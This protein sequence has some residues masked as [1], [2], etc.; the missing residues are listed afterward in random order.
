MLRDEK[1]YGG[2]IL[3][4]SEPFL[5]SSCSFGHSLAVQIDDLNTNYFN[6]KYNVKKQEIPLSHILN[7]RN[8]L[9]HCSFSF[10]KCNEISNDRFHCK[11]SAF[12]T[13]KASTRISTLSNSE[14][15]IDVDLEYVRNF[16]SRQFKN[17]IQKLNSKFKIQIF[18]SNNVANQ[19]L[20]NKCLDKWNIKSSMLTSSIT[21]SQLINPRNL[22]K[23]YFKL[24]K[25]YKKKIC[26]I[27]DD[28]RND[29]KNWRMLAEKLGINR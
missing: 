5:L 20:L 28:S 3:E 25:T 16:L 26:K 23:N 6:C 7:G 17:L 14:M 22:T 8:H 21:P 29:E 24:N 4:V 18:K 2:T 12:Q 13:N 11:I 15:T 27:L 1:N 9:I 19:Q 10:V